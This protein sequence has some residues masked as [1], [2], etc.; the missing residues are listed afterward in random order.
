MAVVVAASGVASA[1]TPAWCKVDGRLEQGF[2]DQLKDPN[3]DMGDQVVAVAYMKCNPQY[4]NKA[5]QAVADDGYKRISQELG[6]TD[7]DWADA[8]MYS[9][10][11]AGFRRGNGLSQKD[12]KAK[13][14]EL[15]PIDQFATIQH[16]TVV[17]PGLMGTTDPAYATD[18]FGSKLSATGRV[19]MAYRCL[20]EGGDDKPVW[21]AMC[22]GDLDQL[23]W[24]KFNDELH[25]DKNHTGD[26]RMLIRVVG[27]D[28]RQMLP[29]RK[30]AIADLVAKDKEYQKLFDIAAKERATWDKRWKDRSDLIDVAVSMDDA[31]VSQSRR[32]TDGCHDKTWNLVTGQ[33]KKTAAKAFLTHRKPNAEYDFPED[34]VNNAIGAL[35]VDPET[36]LAMSSYVMCETID[37]K[38]NKLDQLAGRFGARFE[39]WPGYRGPRTATQ[40]DIMLA[41]I[42]LDDRN[43]HLDQ[44]DFQ[45]YWFKNGGEAGG[46]DWTVATVKVDGDT[47]KITFTAKPIKETVD[48]GCTQSNRVHSIRSDGSLE[49][50][51]NCT[52]SKVVTYDHKPDPVTVKARYV[53]GVK[54]GTMVV[55][56]KDV[57]WAVYPKESAALPS[58][59]LGQPVK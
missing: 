31:L 12:S 21:W 1:D 3:R 11:N 7:A 29:A 14:S 33:I 44:P 58:Y 40:S 13:W 49:Y 47:A 57:V 41:N 8:A 32:A 59:I 48:T 22:Q 39:R 52:G 37:E 34:S 16:P 5:D 19:A 50:E 27:H 55:V 17:T 2:A 24:A 54:A 46:T 53:T 25:A 23:D 28:V 43:A 6:M 4:V 42:V 20:S 30:K 9:T 45:R 38:D 26:V 36:Y 56:A 15:D 35:M 51:V 18:A 10:T